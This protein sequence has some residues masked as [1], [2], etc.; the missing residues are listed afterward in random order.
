M[1]FSTFRRSVQKVVFEVG[2]PE[3]RVFEA[4]K[5]VFKLPLGLFWAKN[6]L[7]KAFLGPFKASKRAENE[8]FGGEQGEIFDLPEIGPE[9]GF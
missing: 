1:K 8:H 3:K 4:V 2:K 6:G 9:G 5:G 7:K